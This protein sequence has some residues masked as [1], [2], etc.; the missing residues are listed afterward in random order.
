VT[1]DNIFGGIFLVALGCWTRV[2]KPGKRLPVGKPICVKLG[3]SM[4]QTKRKK[5]ATC[6]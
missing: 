5:K 1:L 6:N 2:G 4:A 3:N